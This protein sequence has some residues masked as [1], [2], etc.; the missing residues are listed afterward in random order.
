MDRIAVTVRTSTASRKPTR[1]CHLCA[2]PYP[3]LACSVCTATWCRSCLSA[4]ELDLEACLHSGEGCLVCR[5]VC[6]CTSCAGHIRNSEVV[7]CEWRDEV[8][9]LR[10]LLEDA[11][12]KAEGLRQAA[13]KKM[14]TGSP[15]L[16]QHVSIDRA[17][18]NEE[19]LL[20]TVVCD[21]VP[22]VLRG[23]LD[24]PHS[25]HWSLRFLRKNYG[26]TPVGVR[27]MLIDDEDDGVFSILKDGVHTIRDFLA[28]APARDY[29]SDIEYEW[30]DE[31]LD[32][33]EH[34]V[35]YAKDFSFGE[36]VPEWRDDVPKLVPK[37]LHSIPSSD[38]LS[39]C[40]PDEVSQVGPMVLMAYIG[41]PGTRTPFHIDKL[42]SIAYNLHM[43]GETTKVWYMVHH[44]DTKKLDAIIRCGSS[45]LR[46]E[47]VW[48]DPAILLSSDIRLWVIRQDVGDMVIVPP[49]NPHQVLNE[50]TQMSLAIAA[51]IVVDAALPLSLR[52]MAQNRDKNI[53]SVY[54]IKA[55]IYYCVLDTLEQLQRHAAAEQA[56]MFFDTIRNF[57][58]SSYWITPKKG[59]AHA[60]TL[61]EP[62]RLMGRLAVL[63][64][65]LARVVEEEVLFAGEC[66]DGYR[67]DDSL[68]HLR[69]CNMCGADIFNRRVACTSCDTGDGFDLCLHCFRSDKAVKAHYGHKMQLM[70]Y[71]PLGCLRDLTRLVRAVLQHGPKDSTHEDCS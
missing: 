58:V 31:S 13:S 45:K 20:R 4:D 18:F 64:P 7:R 25:P 55:M 42:D 27:Y 53:N 10:Q 41:P 56:G 50:G 46:N 70:E 23:C 3:H 48:L 5:R 37:E 60:S 12:R 11:R 30:N 63:E 19:V 65:M 16:L 2:S 66:M 47:N 52:V 61:E 39:C 59:S 24:V 6:P 8:T 32:L 69:L 67:S 49:G 51:N 57:A 22:L 26:S 54:R 29:R 35:S 9:S 21:R 40:Q 28:R 14:S 68:P 71:L 44:D 38:I 36:H 43:E 15:H 34:V 17:A 62:H 33:M 1:P